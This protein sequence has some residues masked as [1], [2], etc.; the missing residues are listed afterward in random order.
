MQRFAAAIDQEAERKLTCEVLVQ[1]RLGVERFSSRKICVHS[2]ARKSNS[3]TRNLRHFTWLS[4][5]WV[6]FPVLVRPVRLVKR[7]GDNKLT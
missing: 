3:M 1:T 5:L 4:L 6:G 2:K 7:V